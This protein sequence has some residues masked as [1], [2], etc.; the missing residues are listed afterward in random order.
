[1]KNFKLT[2]DSYQKF[3]E[4]N[5]KDHQCRLDF[6]LIENKTE[7]AAT[8]FEQHLMTLFRQFLSKPVFI[9][10]TP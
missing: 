7:R 5:M 6:A 3:L 9:Q 1:M 4:Q 2:E 10:Q 8:P